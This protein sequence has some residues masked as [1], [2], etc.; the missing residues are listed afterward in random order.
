MKTIKNIVSQ[1]S[2]EAAN[3]LKHFL[4][5]IK[6]ALVHRMGIRKCMKNYKNAEMLRVN[7]GC[8]SATKDGFLNLDFSPMA[9]VRLD[10]RRPIPLQDKCASFVYS[11]HF[12]EHLSYPEGVD[13]FFT[14][15][16]RILEPGGQISISV[17]D[18]EWPLH[19][20]ANNGS[21]YLATCK[22][23]KWHPSGC[24]TFM[25]HI[26]Y[27]FRQRW[28]GVSY[29]HFEN[30]RFA[31]DYETMGKKLRQCGFVNVEKRDYDPSLDSAHR[32]I[33]SLFVTAFKP[34]MPN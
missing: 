25:E 15:C 2:P 29:S 33:G 8:G 19:E 5:E 14:D 11:E 7:F 4:S 21:V 17:P 13:Q 28:S 31:W 22:R 12:V 1:V 3:H 18:T 10:L 24:E 9:D 23:H 16:F 32:E 20:Y 26:N 27:H 6:I 34:G 30:H